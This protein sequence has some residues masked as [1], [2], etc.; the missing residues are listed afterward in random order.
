MGVVYF[1]MWAIYIPLTYRWA[2]KMTAEFIEEGT[3]DYKRLRKRVSLWVSLRVMWHFA[4]ICVPFSLGADDSKEAA[5]VFGGAFFTYLMLFPFMSITNW[6]GTKKV[7]N[8]RV[9]TPA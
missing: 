7:F 8:S 4:V 2:K 1:L 3:T 9:A 6:R 5:E